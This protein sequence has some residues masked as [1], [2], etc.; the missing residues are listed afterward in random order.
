MM[1]MTSRIRNGIWS[2]LI[3][4]IVTLLIWLWAAGE[5]RDSRTFNVVRLQFAVTEPANWVITPP[6]QPLTIVVEGSP[7]SLQRADQLF[8]QALKVTLT[9]TRGKQV[10]D[11]YE[12]L[13]ALDEFRELGVRLVSTEPQA[14]EVELDEIVRTQVRVKPVLPGVTTEGEIDVEPSEVTVAAPSQAL[15]RYQRGVTVEAP[16]EGFEIES[17]Q[18][19]ERQSLEV[20]LRTREGF[21]PSEVTITPP[22]AR[23]TF[24]VRSRTRELVLDTVPVQL[25]TPPEAIRSHVVELD[26]P[27]LSQVPIVADAELIKRI[28]NSEVP[29]VAVVHLS[30]REIQTR[31]DS[32]PIS[33]LVALLPDGNGGVRGEQVRVRQ[34]VA[35]SAPIVRLRITELPDS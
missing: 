9:A 14:V 13:P 17:F 22:K 27:E 20:K 2:H 35:G 12:R 19:G 15:A 1:F 4:T 24:T 32:K 11:V 23:I 21:A 10:I 31:I 26:T 30:E 8:R 5:T 29:V 33:Y 34:P 6:Q 18:P 28:E 25:S 16:V 3:V 7:F